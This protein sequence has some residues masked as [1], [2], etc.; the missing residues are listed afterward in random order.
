MS[1]A[2]Y[3]SEP[4]QKRWGWVP[5]LSG[6][7]KI[8][9]PGKISDE[10]E[11]RIKANYRYTY[12]YDGE[13]KITASGKL[14]KVEINIHDKNGI[15]SLEIIENNAEY[16]IREKVWEEFRTMLDACSNSVCDCSAMNKLVDA[17]TCEE[18]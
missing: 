12:T 17:E 11:R 3:Y 6:K 4:S 7:G 5:N 8:C 9:S 14:G 10:I 13:S 2:P 16:D 1:R 15:C 18:V